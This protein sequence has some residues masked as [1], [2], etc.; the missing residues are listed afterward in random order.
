MKDTHST[1][2]ATMAASQSAT[3]RP[4]LSTGA[5]IVFFIVLGLLVAIAPLFLNLSPYVL[6]IFMQAATYSVA[7]L[8]MTIV[9]GYAGQINLA[10][11]TFFGLGAYAVAIGTVVLGLNFWIALLMGI[12]MAVVAGF[13][14]GLT[15][16]R[17][18]GH[19]LAMITISFQIIFDLVL[20]NWS[21]VTQGPDGVA[22][23]GRPSLFGFELIDDRYYLLLCMAILYA[24]IFMVWWLPQTRTGRGMR[25]V[26]ENELA[27]EVSGI[28]TLRVKV[29]AFT[30]GA[31]LAGVGGAFY[32]AGF[33]YISPDNFN[34][35]RSIEFLT[36]VLLG[37]AQSAFGGVLGTS[38]LILLPEWLR[39]LKEVYLAVYGLAVILIMVFLPAGIWGLL[40]APFDRHRK[41]SAIDTDAIAA[42]DLTVPIHDQS[43]ILQIND[44]R[45][46][47][48]GVKAVD[49]VSVQVA[50]GTVHALIG[51]NGSGKT[52]TLNVLNGIY[53]ATSGNVIFDGTDITGMSPHERAGLGI[54]RTF[55]NIRLFPTMSVVE[56]VMIGAQRANNPIE[57][58]REALRQRALSAL[59]FVEMADKAELIV[60]NLPYGHQRLIEIARALAGHPRFLLLDEPA[61]GLNQTEKKELGDLLKRLSGHGLTIFLIEHD[62]GLIEQ[63]SDTITVLNFGKKIAEGTPQEVL[64]HPD[65][66]TAYLGE[67]AHAAT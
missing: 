14:L 24:A 48:G 21:Q 30:M 15:T 60:Q 2:A 58:G 4:A 25:A 40:R 53:S 22:G 31:G 34:F 9:L 56:N 28:N 33:A 32:A 37:G 41:R 13:V 54:G 19:Y 59:K 26:R 64:R 6:N 39:F 61:A 42:L 43:P 45:K 3:T 20:V 36:M 16:L 55:Q 18:G 1:D 46:Y 10:Q 50:R 38:L 8:G 62:I 5:K 49:G 44:V 12:G 35:M 65:V 7:V 47:F 51:P 63:I 11:A 52:T 67:P 23:I 66:I 57:P 27:A 17:L 29:I